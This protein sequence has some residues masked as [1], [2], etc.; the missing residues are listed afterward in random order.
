MRYEVSERFKTKRD[1][2]A[3]VAVLKEQFGKVAKK[4]NPEGDGLRVETVA[5][6]FITT[7]LKDS[8]S[9]RLTSKEGGYLCTADVTYGTSWVFWLYLLLGF[10][11]GPFFFIVWVVLVL[12]FFY[13]KKAV[14]EGF[15]KVFRRVKDEVED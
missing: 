3:V 6:N 5:P 11:L 15:E 14:R 12:F 13:Q 1:A 10:L 2:T 7:S 9:V 8:A 4:V